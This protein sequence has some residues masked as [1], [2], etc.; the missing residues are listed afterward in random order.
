MAKGYWGPVP[1]FRVS[2]KAIMPYSG[3][4][5]LLKN[6][7]GF[8]D[9]PGGKIEASE[10]AVGALKRECQEEIG[11]TLEPTKIIDTSIRVRN[12][13]PSIFIVFY[14]C[15]EL[16][17]P[18]TITLSDEHLLFDFFPLES[19]MDLP[20]QAAYRKALAACSKYQKE[21]AKA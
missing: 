4:F 6:K 14:L 16:T 2:V 18:K 1:L 17:K 11:I 21:N 9:L 20:I 7:K 19:L 15:P 3:R 12:K 8:W 10:D 13:K 5:L